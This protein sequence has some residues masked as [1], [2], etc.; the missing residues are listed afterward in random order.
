MKLFTNQKET[1]RAIKAAADQ[2]KKWKRYESSSN[3]ATH[4]RKSGTVRSRK[5]P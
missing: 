2:Y 5:K 3:S 4:K 1:E